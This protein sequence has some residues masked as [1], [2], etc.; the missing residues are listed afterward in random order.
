MS[1]IAYHDA[2]MAV[3]MCLAAHVL[4]QVISLVGWQ[5]LVKFLLLLFGLWAC[6]DW[7]HRI[8]ATTQHL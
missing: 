2:V 7:H 3:A 1:R 8:G 4:A 5:K 6:A